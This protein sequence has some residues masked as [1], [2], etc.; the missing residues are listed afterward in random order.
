MGTGVLQVQSCPGFLG[1]WGCSLQ[2]CGGTFHVGL[3]RSMRGYVYA[4]GAEKGSALIPT[5]PPLFLH[6][7][8]RDAFK[9]EVIVPPPQSERAYSG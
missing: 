6:D 9:T 5:L 4:S 3:L 8:P 7:A 1:S 2:G